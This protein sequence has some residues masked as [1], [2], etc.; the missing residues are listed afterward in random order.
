MFRLKRLRDKILLL[1]LGIISVLGVSIFI[2]IS[3]Q[4]S[5]EIR[6]DV[7]WELFKTRS[8]FVDEFQ[9]SRNTQLLSNCR[10]AAEFPILK[11]ALVIKDRIAVLSLGQKLQKIVNSDIFILTDEH[12]AI[13]ASVTEPD[14]YGNDT[15]WASEVNDALKGQESV[16]TVVHTSSGLYQA[17][18]CPVRLGE[19]RAVAGVLI[20]GLLIND[21]A[22]RGI[23]VITESDL[24]FSVEGRIVAS[25]F[26]KSKIRD[27]QNV[28]LRHGGHN[29]GCV[30]QKVNI[31]NQEF[32]SLCSVINGLGEK[33]V[34]TYLILKSLS[35]PT[36]RL[37]NIERVLLGI[38]LL[39][40]S[41]AA[42]VGFFFARGITKSVGILSTRA[43]QIV[44][45][46]LSHRIPVRTADEIG[47]LT[48]TFNEMVD[49]LEKD[50][51]IL[52]ETQLTTMVR[53]AMLAE[54][55]DPETGE[56]LERLKEY[57]RL[58]AEGLRRTEKYKDLVDDEY[59]DMLVQSSPL[60][61]IGKVG[62]PDDVL[63]KNGRLT[64]DEFEIMK[65]HSIKGAEILKGPEFLKMGYE[66]ALSHHEKYDGSGYPYGLSGDAIPL[67]AR[68][69]ALVD[70]YDALTSKRVY[71]EA[72]SHEEAYAIIL[73]ESGKSFD[74]EIIQVF[75]D[76]VE[77][78]IE[79]KEKLQPVLAFSK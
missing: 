72:M 27:V 23:K 63:L 62:I 58:L 10:I 2:F 36:A 68:I 39:V 41:C 21:E 64:K 12:G 37:K 6:T 31:K 77:K 15:L 26:P 54:K 28:L 20:L 61:D 4:I 17:A 32:L 79:V 42:L 11:T 8:V 60:H 14:K 18:F 70:M 24:V 3:H 9:E 35:G 29:N 57:S 75:K 34:G 65:H 78:F 43:E 38:I 1:V 48:I 51:K 46:D 19:D 49:S 71:K 66:I 40:C 74:P 56:H 52:K 30:P 45:G 13:L 50:I 33:P 44:H 76:N 59:I 7:T 55:R 5:D 47:A 69:V 53:L 16:G 67:S 25:S 22:V 73:G